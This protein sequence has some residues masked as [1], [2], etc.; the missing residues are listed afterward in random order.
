VQKSALEA[1]VDHQECYDLDEI[2]SYLG[3][4]QCGLCGSVA[5]RDGRFGGDSFEPGSDADGGVVYDA[6]LTSEVLPI[7]RSWEKRQP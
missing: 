7:N 2:I 5:A 4:G 1:I 6:K 3:N